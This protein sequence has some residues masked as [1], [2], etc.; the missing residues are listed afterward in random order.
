[1]EIRKITPL[2]TL[3]AWHCSSEFVS[4][5]TCA[6]A[7]ALDME[8]HFTFRYHPEAD[9]DEPPGSVCSEFTDFTC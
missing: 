9:G 1:M 5:F 4:Q 8:L 2:D 7:K 6:L 3:Q